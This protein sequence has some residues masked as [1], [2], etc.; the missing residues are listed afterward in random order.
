MSGRGRRLSPGSRPGSGQTAAECPPVTGHPRDAGSATLEVG[1]SETPAPLQ[2]ERLVLGK[3]G[4]TDD[5]LT[6]PQTHFEPD[7]VE[8]FV[9]KAAFAI[10]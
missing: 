2:T 7:V 3:C 9:I 5:Q 8:G 4:V 6:L 10:Q 1:S